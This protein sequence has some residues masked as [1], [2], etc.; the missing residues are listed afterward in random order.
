IGGINSLPI[1]AENHA[2]M[3]G[4][5]QSHAATLLVPH[6]TNVHGSDFVVAMPVGNNA[7][8]FNIPTRQTCVA[9]ALFTWPLRHSDQQHDTVIH[10]DDAGVENANHLHVALRCW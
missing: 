5:V 8:I 6:D 9:T 4:E 1:A 3:R 10:S 7:P 2:Q